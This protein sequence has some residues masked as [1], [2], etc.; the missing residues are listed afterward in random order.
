VTRGA[1]VLV[2]IFYRAKRAG[3]RSTARIAR[4]TATKTRRATY[5]LKKTHGF[6]V[7]AVRVAVYSIS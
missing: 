3:E 4:Y 2:R 7:R 5:R 6:V 1:R